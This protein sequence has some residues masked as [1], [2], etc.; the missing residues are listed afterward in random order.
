MKTTNATLDAT[1]ALNTQ[2]LADVYYFEFRE[3]FQV[4][5]SADTDIVYGATTFL[6]NG[7]V[8]TRGQA[9]S[10]A[11]LSVDTMD[12]SLA[13]HGA[14]VGG[15]GLKA[16]ALQG[17]FDNVRVV[18]S[19]AYMQTWNVNPQLVTVF[20]GYVVE[21]NPSST[22]VQ[23]TVKSALNKLTEQLPRRTIQP[24]CPYRVYD[25]GCGLAAASFTHARTVAAGSNTSI[26]CLSSASTNANVGGYLQFTSGVL[27]G[28]LR[29]ITGVSGIDI[30]LNMPLP[31]IPVIGVG[32]N[33]VKGCD[34]T[35]TACRTFSN[36]AKYGGFPDTPKPESVAK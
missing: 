23:L 17:M 26:V 3:G 29:T 32:V 15:V 4:W 20:D 35:R 36:I 27:T 13:P 9:K 25:S 16:A 30:T 31:S 28:V 12:I 21:A 18:V 22:E 11:G 19:R 8:I 10:S 33:V 5:T 7:P 6:C 24:Q 2:Q 14:T 1:L 34:K